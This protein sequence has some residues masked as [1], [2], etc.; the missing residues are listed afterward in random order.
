MRFARAD[1]DE[2]MK[3]TNRSNQWLVNSHAGHVQGIAELG[4]M[5]T[6]QM[7]TYPPTLVLTYSKEEA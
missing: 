6:L 5:R 2:W 4:N 7:G 3:R 1:E